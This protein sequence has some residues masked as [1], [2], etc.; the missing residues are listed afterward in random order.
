MSMEPQSSGS[1]SAAA[2]V[3]STSPSGPNGKSTTTPPKVSQHNASVELKGVKPER[4]GTKGSIPL[5]EDIMQIARIGE[6]PAMQRILEE[7]KLTANYKDEEG[8][9]PLHVRITCGGHPE[10]IF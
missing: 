7:K 1:S 9:T 4:E 6:I 5:G 10:K 8:I 3:A 2:G